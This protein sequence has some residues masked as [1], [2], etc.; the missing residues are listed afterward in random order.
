MKKQSFAASTLFTVSFAVYGVLLVMMTLL[1]NKLS[2]GGLW[3]T[4]AHQ[5]RSI[6]LVLFD[7]FI[8][9]PIWWGPWTNTFGNIALFVPFGFFLYR[10]LHSHHRSRFTFLET[11]LFTG[12]TSLGIEVLQWVFAVGYSDVDDLLFN[13]I[14]GLIGA[15]IAASVAARTRKVLSGFVLVASLIVMG[16]MVYSSVMG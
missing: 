15:V 5:Y 7:G 1:K 3:S 9:P 16:I 10:V 8:N 12:V 4:E 2:I 13:T 11:V 6:D 14:G